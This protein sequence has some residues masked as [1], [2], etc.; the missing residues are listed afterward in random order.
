MNADNL[1]SRM[2]WWLAGVAREDMRRM[3]ERT[4]LQYATLGLVVALNLLLLVAV[5]G[6]VGLRYFGLIG[7]LPGFVVPA[8]FALGLDRLIGMR[9]RPLS[10]E[11]ADLEPAG[12]TPRRSEPLLRLL[13]ALAFSALTTF[14]FMLDLSAR[15]IETAQVA[16]AAGA[17]QALRQEYEARTRA[18]A[19]ADQ[20]LTLAR[21]AQIEADRR[22]LA[23]RQ[24]SLQ[25]VQDQTTAQA[26]SARDEAAAE[27]GG[28]GNRQEGEGPRFRARQ[29]LAAQNEQATLEAH[30]AAVTVALQLAALDQEAAALRQARQQ[31]G[32][33]LATALAGINERMAQD[34]RYQRP[35][36]GL[37][38]DATTFVR[39]YSDP[40]E[41]PGRWLLTALLLPV[42][43][44]LECAALLG[45][46]LNPISPL[47]VLRMAGNKSSAAAI[48]AQ[49]AVDVASARSRHAAVRT[50]PAPAAAAATAATAATAAP[51][52]GADGPAAS[53]PAAPAPNTLMGSAVP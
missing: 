30:Q 40:Q 41:G 36:Q 51:P 1:F 47:D 18:P 10:D 3:P 23:G 8:L 33:N 2:L 49:C 25:A 46:A 7:L 16:T 9:R 32:A 6:K 48:V 21:L 14:T 28:L 5:W 45:F 17:N 26:R 4:R 11:L 22:D 13:F 53:R 15:S 35:G 34:P 27:A 29:Q 20:V 42:L 43:M 19:E 52:Q 31:A 44:A 24:A 37:F 50:A 39:L 38:S 12:P